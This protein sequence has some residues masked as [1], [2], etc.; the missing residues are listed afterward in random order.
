[1][2]QQ[3]VLRSDR[4]QSAQCRHKAVAARLSIRG[5]ICAIFAFLTVDWVNP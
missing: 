3:R 2:T 4:R 5:A 1:V